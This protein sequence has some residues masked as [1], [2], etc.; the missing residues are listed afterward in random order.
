[1]AAVAGTAVGRGGAMEGRGQAMVEAGAEV[2]VRVVAKMGAVA[3]TA[4]WAEEPASRLPSVVPAAAG[5]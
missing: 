3:G 1:M 2:R 5:C 4:P